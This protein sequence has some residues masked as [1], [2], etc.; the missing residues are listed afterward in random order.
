MGSHCSWLLS[1][2]TSLFAAATQP[3]FLAV[4]YKDDNGFFE[5]QHQEN[6]FFEDICIED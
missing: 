6:A 1:K 2:Q 3:V 4:S 5:D